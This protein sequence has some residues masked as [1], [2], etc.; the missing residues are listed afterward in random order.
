TIFRFVDREKPT[1]L[2]D[3]V[4][5]LFQRKADVR[6]IFN[7][8]WTRGTKIPRQVSIQGVSMTVW[9]DP[10]C[11]KAVG[12]L[13]L[14]LPRP[15]VG[16]GIVVKVWQKK[17]GKKVENFPHINDDEFFVLRRKLARWAVDNT[18]AI[19]DAKPLLPANFT[20]R[21]GDNWKLLLAVA[22]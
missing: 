4:D 10:F 16:R 1:L 9:F 8:A 2:I 17:G 3:E 11:P 12:L 21:A 14:N 18:A 13:G 7:A 15:L 19:K 6:H 22:E 20:N 5:D